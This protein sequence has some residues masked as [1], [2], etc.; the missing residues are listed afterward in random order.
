[1]QEE[2]HEPS[3]WQAPLPGQ[4]MSVQL[5]HCHCPLLHKGVGTLQS[6]FV[7]HPTQAPKRQMAAVG[8]VQSALLRQPTQ[9][10]VMSQNGVPPLQVAQL[11]PTGPQCVASMG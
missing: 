8:E 10:P 11:P 1:M 3:G 7:A 2:A 4:P 5:R 9:V 6:E